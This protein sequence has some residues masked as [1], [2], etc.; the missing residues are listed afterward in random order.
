MDLGWGFRMIILAWTE[1]ETSL[2]AVT[3]I[4]QFS[5]TPAEGQEGEALADAP[6]GWPIHGAITFDNFVASYTD[7]GAPILKDINL[8]IAPGEKIGICGRTG[9]PL[10]L[11]STYTKP[12]HPSVQT[13]PHQAPKIPYIA[14]IICSPPP[15]SGKSSLL[16]TLFALLHQ[17][18]G[19]L[20][21]D[22][23]P[24]SHIPLPLLRSTIIALPQ[25]PFFLRGTVRH[26]LSPWTAPAD[27]PRAP[28]PDARMQAAL[29]EVQLWEKLS[30]AAAPGQSALDVSLDHVESLLSQGERQLFCLA[31]AVLMGGRIVV[32]DEATSRYVCVWDPYY[33][34]S[35]LPFPFLLSSGGAVAVGVTLADW[36]LGHSVD[37]HTD[38]LMQRVLRSAFADRTIIAVAHRLDTILDFDRVV[39]MDK[40][41]IVEVGPPSVL[42]KKEG[43]LFRVLVEAQGR[44]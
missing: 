17:T 28:I 27:A 29:Q 25:D 11:S 41:R 1:L 33:Y 42:M 39:V 12:P 8:D 26:N 9:K 19:T 32:L 15:G 14:S 44:K 22:G 38:A 36:D 21:I 13:T 35:N 37:A 24:T 31:R 3:R 2:S 4:R 18:H 40:G 34:D 16:A 43:G 7:G 30:A 6:E 10:F 5:A 23:I 20:S